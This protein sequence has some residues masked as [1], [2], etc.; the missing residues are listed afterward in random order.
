MATQPIQAA[1]I[2]KNVLGG[3]IQTRGSYPRGGLE[4]PYFVEGT[5]Q[6]YTV[7]Q[8]VMWSAGK[9]VLATASSNLIAALLGLAETAATGVASTKTMATIL[10]EGMLLVVNVVN[11]AGTGGVTATTDFGLNLNLDISSGGQLVLNVEKT[12]DATKAY[13]KVV[14]AYTQPGGFPDGDAAIGDTHGRYVVRIPSQQA[15]QLG[16][17]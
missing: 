14:T 6:V 12:F 4:E 2:I 3:G 16:A 8:P 5:S 9:I 13:G 11:N 1:R 15:L 17:I 7:G 10:E